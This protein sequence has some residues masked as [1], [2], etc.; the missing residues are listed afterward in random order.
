MF[1]RIRYKNNALIQLKSNWKNSVFITAACIILMTI[2]KLPE[3]VADLSESSDITSLAAF[4]AFFVLLSAQFYTF[5]KLA[6]ENKKI[7]FDLFFEGLLKWLKAIQAAFWIGL[8][9]ILWSLLFFFPAVVKFFA[10]SQT[11]FL[12][13]EYPNLGIRKAMKISRIITNGYKGELF[14]MALSFSGWFFLSCISCGIGFLWL[15]PYAETAFANCYIELK[16]S[17]LKSGK[18]IPEDLNGQYRNI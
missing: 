14:I 6:Q 18:I 16:T 15:I 11:L 12:I 9:L 1:D 7:T 3:T 8:Y 5:L 10:Y 13:N 4:F 2:I 17:A